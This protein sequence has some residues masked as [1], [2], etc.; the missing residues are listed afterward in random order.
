M[1]KV[2]ETLPKG[3]IKGAVDGGDSDSPR[4]SVLCSE[5]TT[6]QRD[7]LDAHAPRRLPVRTILNYFERSRTNVLGGPNNLRKLQDE[8]GILA[9]VTSIR[10]L[11]LVWEEQEGGL[12]CVDIHAG[13][14]VEVQSE[15]EVK[16]KGMILEF[17]SSLVLSR[18]GQTIPRGRVYLM[19]IDAK[20]MRPTSKLPVWVKE[21]LQIQT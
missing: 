1:T 13:D 6:I 16:R 19:M 21:L 14:S 4:S 15:V 17:H 10:D 7:E 3:A 8:D 11:S 18:T 12:A 2:Q 9:V 5:A 20:T